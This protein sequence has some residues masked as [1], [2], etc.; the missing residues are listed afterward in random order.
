[1][2]IG[3][4]VASA[5]PRLGGASASVPKIAQAL[6]ELGHR[7]ELLST[8]SQTFDPSGEGHLDIRRFK[9]SWP[10]GVS[11]SAELE[12]HLSEAHFDLIHSNGLWQRTTYYSDRTAR[13]LSIPHVLSPRGMLS[14]WALSHKRWQKRLA[15]LLVHPGLPK[16]V[17][18][19]HATSPSEAEDIRK[20]GFRQPICVAPNGVE[21]PDHEEEAVARRYWQAACPQAFDRPTALFYSRFH[22]SKR[23]LELID[24]WIAEAPKDWLLLVV[25]YPQ[26]Y[27][28]AQLNDYVVRG[29]GSGNVA[30]FDGTD[31]P[32][33]FVAA[34]LFLLPSL[35]ES[36]GLVVAEA[37]ASGL[38]VLATDTSPWSHI[39]Q[40]E[41]GW[42][43]SWETYRSALRD[44]LA[45]G[46]SV[47]RER[48]QHARQWISS[49]YT[50]EKSARILAAFYESLK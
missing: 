38:P 3:Q 27:E 2:R 36:Y 50:W 25:G 5:D 6:A 43:G 48:G 33:P 30:V 29:G 45:L 13:R 37:L 32:P 19:F 4:I 11:A 35:I 22:R 39:N 41:F 10:Q 24:L 34:S 44:A 42:C 12:S 14:P 40:T 21:L 8:D 9:R 28:V 26:E 46:T 47:L 1:M 18:A 17:K 31:T 49:E 7:V 16:R 15:G 23:L 20:A